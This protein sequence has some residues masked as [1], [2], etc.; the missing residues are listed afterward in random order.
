MEQYSTFE[1]YER[2]MKGLPA[3]PQSEREFVYDREA[4]STHSFRIQ[5]AWKD[6]EAARRTERLE[7]REPRALLEWGLTG[8]LK[9]VLVMLP[10]T[11][12]IAWLAW[13]VVSNL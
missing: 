6:E 11:A 1:E 4:A 9:F 13:S 2:V 3:E 12:V 10:V 5:Q 8:V 7:A